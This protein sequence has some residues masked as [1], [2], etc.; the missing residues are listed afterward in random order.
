M[1]NTVLFYEII[2][3]GKTFYIKSEFYD[4]K[5]KT[6]GEKKRYAKKEKFSVNKEENSSSFEEET[7]IEQKTENPCREFSKTQANNEFSPVCE[8]LNVRGQAPKKYFLSQ[9]KTNSEILQ[10]KRQP[11]TNIE[12]NIENVI[13]RKTAMKRAARKN[14]KVK[15]SSSNKENVKIYNITDYSGEGIDKGLTSITF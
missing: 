15:N 13:G 5:E 11:F 2:F 12:N 9:W 3:S 1:C 6:H 7:A 8:K 10:L 14:I 4:H